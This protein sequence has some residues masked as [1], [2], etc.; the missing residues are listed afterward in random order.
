MSIG[1]PEQH[2]DDTLLMLVSSDVVISTAE[3]C[4]YPNPQY[5]FANSTTASIVKKNATIGKDGSEG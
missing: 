1:S 3:S 4:T 5:N 2:P